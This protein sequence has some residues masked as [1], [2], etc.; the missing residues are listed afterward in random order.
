MNAFQQKGPGYRTFLL[1]FV[2]DRLQFPSILGNLLS[3]REVMPDS[4][5][6]RNHRNQLSSAITQAV[7]RLEQFLTHW[8]DYT[9]YGD[10][11]HER[12]SANGSHKNLISNRQVVQ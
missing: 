10:Y 8:T 3:V 6:Q 7:N 2:V 4:P 12:I 9:D 5:D 11:I 1:Q